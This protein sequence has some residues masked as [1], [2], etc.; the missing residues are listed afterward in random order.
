MKSRFREQTKETKSACRVTASPDD[1]AWV[2]CG[3]CRRAMRQGDCMLD[4]LGGRLRCAY[5]DCRPEGNFAFESLYGWDAYRL[6][7]ELE[8]ANWPEEPRP[9]E[10]YEPAG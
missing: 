4:E 5:D 2:Y 6:A 10:C 7:H 8:T 3:V 9:G 1:E